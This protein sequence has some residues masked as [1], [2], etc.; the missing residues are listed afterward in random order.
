MEEPLKSEIG[1]AGHYQTHGKRP[2]REDRSLKSREF[3]E[4]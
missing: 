1:L 2:N 3:C 4:S